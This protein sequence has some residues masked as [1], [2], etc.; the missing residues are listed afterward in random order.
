MLARLAEIVISWQKCRLW[1]TTV[2]A[3]PSVRNIGKWR[4]W[5][6]PSFRATLFRVVDIPADLTLHTRFRV[7]TRAHQA[8]KLFTHIGARERGGQLFLVVT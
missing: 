3:T 5:I 1:V 2:G 7:N 4:T 8:I 6:D